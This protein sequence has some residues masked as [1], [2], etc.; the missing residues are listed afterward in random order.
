MNLVPSLPLFDTR[1]HTTQRRLAPR[2]EDCLSDCGY[3][4][5]TFKENLRRRGCAGIA[6][7]SF[8]RSPLQSD[9][10]TRTIALLV[11]M[12]GK[13]LA[14]QIE[15]GYQAGG[16]E[17]FLLL[18]P[19]ES[20]SEE[21]FRQ[22]IV[23][24]RMELERYFSL[25]RLT[26][27][28]GFDFAGTARLMTVDG[29]FLMDR[30]G[31]TADNVLF[32]AFQELFSASA[33][34]RQEK[35]ADHTALEHIIAN[36][37]VSPVFQPIFFLEDGTVHGYE[38]LSRLADASQFSS[39]EELFT[40]ATTHGLTAP[41]ERLCRKKAL[42]G[43]RELAV[44]GQIFLNVCPALLQASDHERGFT[45]A[46]L[47]HLCIE[48]SRVTFELTERTLIEDYSLFRRVLSH[49]R[50]QGYTI[51]IDD[52]GSG[53]AGLQMLAQL[54]PDYVK[55]AR[56]LVDDIHRSSTRQALVEALVTFCNRIGARVIAEGIERREELDYLI[57]AGVTF[58]QGYF[59]ARP[60]SHP[61]PPDFRFGN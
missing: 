19:A 21:L 13:K 53:Y 39:T 27:Q 33:P 15:G 45:A 43:A 31:D 28:S 4:F 56:F 1:L 22:D 16:G 5:H 41:L 23:T 25:P 37:L 7:I 32:R 34:A 61:L 3:L 38:A 11:R 58:G 44:P 50:E 30:H 17:F 40:A 55:L 10:T 46:L 29:V 36:G 54:E 49:Y 6:A 60:S 24:I 8:A 18:V 9:V 42:T 20:Y 52:L 26:A 2:L 12:I 48:R 51:A 14:G 35:K 59:L 47:D 57:S